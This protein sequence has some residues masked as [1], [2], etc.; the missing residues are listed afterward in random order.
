MLILFLAAALVAPLAAAAEDMRYWTSYS[1]PLD[2]TTEQRIR[3]DNYACVREVQMASSGSFSFSFGP[4]WWVGLNQMLGNNKAER[5]ANR[6]IGLCMQ[7]RGWRE[8]NSDDMKRLIKQPWTNYPAP[9]DAPTVSV[10]ARDA[11]VVD[12]D[13]PEKPL[14]INFDLLAGCLTAHGYRQLKDQNEANQIRLLRQ[15]QHTQPAP[16]PEATVP[17]IE[18]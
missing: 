11:G 8:V 4:P 16:Q 7:S 9:L 18:E 17:P 10:C 1:N 15:Q 12:P 13:S 14:R 2:N 5:N 6:M 3:D